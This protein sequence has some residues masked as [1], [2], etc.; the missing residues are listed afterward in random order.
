MVAGSV[1]IAA[2]VAASLLPRGDVA[3]RGAAL[4]PWLHVTVI[5][6]GARTGFDTA[7]WLFTGGAAREFLHELLHSVS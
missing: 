2:V 1:V 5:V 7:R 6:A 4:L 3:R